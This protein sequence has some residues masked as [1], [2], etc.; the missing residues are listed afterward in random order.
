MQF[1]TA[2]TTATLV[3]SLL[4]A[5]TTAA[6]RKDN[7]RKDFAKAIDVCVDVI[8][9]PNEYN[10]CVLKA[11]GKYKK[12]DGVL[13]KTD[14]CIDVGLLSWRFYYYYPMPSSLANRSA[15]LKSGEF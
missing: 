3:L 8:N 2:T 4:A 14:K 5:T 7:N 1:L 6:L 10:S 15:R 12:Y 9:S 11:I 13:D